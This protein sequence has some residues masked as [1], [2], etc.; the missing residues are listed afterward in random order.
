M[1]DFVEWG[2]AISMGC[3]WGQKAFLEAHRREFEARN[4]AAIDASPVAQALVGFTESH[5]DWNGTAADLLAQLRI[6]ASD[7]GIDIR[8]TDWPKQP[9]VLSRRINETITNRDRVRAILG[10]P[11]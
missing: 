10:L 9:H 8:A 3:G 2:C 6:F 7:A 5:S 4:L 11:C 1:A